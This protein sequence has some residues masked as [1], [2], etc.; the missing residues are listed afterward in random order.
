MLLPQAR[1]CLEAV[2]RTRAFLYCQKIM[3]KGAIPELP[4]TRIKYH[5]NWISKGR[6]WSKIQ[7]TAKGY[8]QKFKELIMKGS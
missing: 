4:D 7:A 6:L 3:A 5:K 1:M 8:R 2:Q